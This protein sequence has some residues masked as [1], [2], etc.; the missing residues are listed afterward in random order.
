MVNALPVTK[1]YLE[2]LRFVSYPRVIYFPCSYKLF[3]YRKQLKANLLSGSRK[4]AGSLMANIGLP[5]VLPL[6]SLFMTLLP[7]LC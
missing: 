6:V 2:M 4:P 5:L 3:E 7:M 1:L